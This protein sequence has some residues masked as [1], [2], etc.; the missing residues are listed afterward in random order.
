M[1]ND[2]ND[3][4]DWVSKA[5]DTAFQ[6]LHNFNPVAT[7]QGVFL[8]VVLKYIVFDWDLLKLSLE[9]N[10]P[11][12]FSIALGIFLLNIPSLFK[13]V[14]NSKELKDLDDL[15]SLIK[16]YQK[17][18]NLTPRDKREQFKNITMRFFENSTYS[19]EDQGNSKKK[20]IK[21]NSNLDDDDKNSGPKLFEIIFLKSSK[22]LS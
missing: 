19:K 17:I 3:Y 11:F 12:V 8:G 21:D 13:K 6:T 20:S 16:K 9:T 15:L 7:S 14:P 5:L 1:P 18:G 4:K 2:P 10:T 22:T